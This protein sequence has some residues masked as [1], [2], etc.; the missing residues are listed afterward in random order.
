MT[1]E[2]QEKKIEER[3]QEELNIDETQLAE[4]L[5]RQPSRFFYWAVSWAL[6]QRK[7]RMTQL[8]GKELEA[9]ISA[10]YRQEMADS[11][12]KPRDVTIRMVEDYCTEHL[13]VKASREESIQSEYLMDM[14]EIAKL[15]FRQR[16]QS[17]VELFKSKW[18]E[19][20]YQEHGMDAMHE[21]V[22]KKRERKERKKTKEE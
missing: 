15:A 8:R 21:E 1:E 11:G 19:K 20:Y 14:L 3:I 9:R 7:H 6:A 16:H 5:Q 13:D 4:E 18:E 17:L 2:K 22:D 12:M 10:A